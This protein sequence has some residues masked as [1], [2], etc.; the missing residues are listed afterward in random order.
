MG[1]ASLGGA[2]QSL[3]GEMAAGE[4][5]GD[6]DCIQSGP[7][8]IPVEDRQA[9]SC[10]YRCIICSRKAGHGKLVTEIQIYDPGRRDS[11]VA[12]D[13]GPR[14]GQIALEEAEKIEGTMLICK[15]AVLGAAPFG[16]QADL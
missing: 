13:A 9:V 4:T 10:A 15:S 14:V 7:G 6:V 5:A 2:P 1:T 8:E 3:S 11:V 16:L 12:S